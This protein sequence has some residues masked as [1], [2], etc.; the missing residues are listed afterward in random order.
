MERRSCLDILVEILCLFDNGDKREEIRYYF[1]QNVFWIFLIQFSSHSYA[2]QVYLSLSSGQILLSVFIYLSS[3]KCINYREQKYVLLSLYF[4][5]QIQWVT[6]FWWINVNNFGRRQ[7]YLKFQLTLG[8]L[9]ASKPHL[10]PCS[11]CFPDQ[12]CV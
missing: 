5:C 2:L 11:F 4:Q 12:V 6:Y 3:S 10:F 7:T 8:F 9:A 1:L